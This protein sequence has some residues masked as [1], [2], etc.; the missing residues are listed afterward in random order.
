MS[1]LTKREIKKLIV[2]GWKCD[3]Y[4]GACSIPA[5]RGK[6]NHLLYD[7]K[8]V[9][10]PADLAGDKNFDGNA[11]VL[12]VGRVIGKLC[13]GQLTEEKLEIPAG[14]FVFFT[15]EECVNMPLD[16]DGSLFMNP[17]ISNLGLHFF[18][19]GHVDPGFH[20]YL[21][22][23]LLNVTNQ[24]IRLNRHE[25]CLYFVLGRTEEFSEP[26]PRFHEHPQF[27]IDE[28]QENLSFGMNPGF[29]LTSADFA[30]KEELNNTRNM[31][32]T[33]V[34][35]AIGILITA[36]IAVILW[37]IGRSPTATG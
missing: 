30:T 35:S 2:N 14:K 24:P 7:P 9:K 19:L 4:K 21:T 10:T 37:L 16:V 36:F 15:T 3:D 34:F 8:G 25:G 26:H 12:H 33:I 11:V 31:L 23:T 22:A 13:N 17:R 29:A 1:D 5:H 20:G 6:V 32:L 27:E 28:A 18:T